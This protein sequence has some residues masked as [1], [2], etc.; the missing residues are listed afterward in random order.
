MLDAADVH[1]KA[2]ILLGINCGFGNADV[3]RLPISALE[4][5]S[6]ECHAIAPN[7]TTRHQE[8]GWV[9]FPRPKTAVPRRCK[10]WPETVAALEASLAVRPEPRG[11]ATSR[12][13]PLVFVTKYGHPWAKDT[14]DNPVAKE[15]AKLLDRLG[16]ARQG[17]GFYA[18]RH[19]FE[20]IAGGSRD[21][22]AVN[23]V[24]GHVDQSMA[25]VY[26][27]RIDDARLE[28]VAAHVR[29]WLFP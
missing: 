27:E 28:A 19:T 10:L 18:L 15:T 24:M 22:V 16:I 2:M 1:L 7:E 14:S 21:Q 17:R 6:T 29:A 8:G 12:G 11:T 23:A 9:N 25:G 3:G 26:R 4:L 20:T 5:N 13:T